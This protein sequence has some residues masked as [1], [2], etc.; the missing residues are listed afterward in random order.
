MHGL[1]NTS[2][3]TLEQ[4]LIIYVCNYVSGPVWINIKVFFTCKFKSYRP[5]SYPY[6]IVGYYAATNDTWL[7]D[8]INWCGEISMV[9][10]SKNYKP[11]WRR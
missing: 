6:K 5:P 4:S 9:F 1:P 3:C 10:K 2:L 8:Y 7:E 11:P